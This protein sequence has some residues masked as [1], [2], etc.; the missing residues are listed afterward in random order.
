MPK[1]R[2]GVLRRRFRPSNLSSRRWHPY[3]SCANVASGENHT[4]H[5]GCLF[6][7]SSIDRRRRRLQNEH[8]SHTGRNLQN[9]RR[10]HHFL[11]HEGQATTAAPRQLPSTP[12]SSFRCTT[13]AK[14]GDK[15]SAVEL[16]I[17]HLYILP[18]TAPQFYSRRGHFYFVD[19]Q[20]QLNSNQ[21]DQR[22]A[23]IKS[24]SRVSH[25]VLPPPF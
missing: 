23:E 24:D 3:D 19:I 6:V 17:D 13:S 21:A 5:E 4:K 8:E 16:E 10:R 1:H 9:H 18:V 22:E 11:F 12:S 7:N 2:G 15:F 14:W 20:R 25:S